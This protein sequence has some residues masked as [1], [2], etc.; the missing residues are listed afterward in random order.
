MPAPINSA[1]PAYCSHAGQN[2]ATPEHAGA[3]FVVLLAF[4][5]A[6]RVMDR[7][8]WVG[9]RVPRV[10]VDAVEN[11]AELDLVFLEGAAEPESAVAVHRLVGMAGGYRGHEVGVRHPALHRVQAAVAEVI[12]E[13]PG[14]EEIVRP[15]EPGGPQH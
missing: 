9:L 14:V 1:I 3:L 15:A 12:A 10:V 7:R 4:D 2:G 6:D 8:E 11:S 13:P 5:G